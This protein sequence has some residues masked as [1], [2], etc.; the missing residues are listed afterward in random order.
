MTTRIDEAIKK[1]D[2]IFFKLVDLEEIFDAMTDDKTANAYVKERKDYVETCIQY[3]KNVSKM[4]E[5]VRLDAA[6]RRKRAE[7]RYQRALKF[8]PKQSGGDLNRRI[9]ELEE[10]VDDLK[11]RLEPK[12]LTILKEKLYDANRW[13]FG[14]FRSPSI[15]GSLKL[16]LHHWNEVCLNDCTINDPFKK[17]IYSSAFKKHYNVTSDDE[18]VKITKDFVIFVQI[19]EHGCYRRLSIPQ[20]KKYFGK[21]SVI[22]EGLC[23]LNT[24]KEFKH[25]LATSALKTLNLL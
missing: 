20:F 15:D 10:V 7:E 6:E 16:S 12:P 22:V 14:C 18:K 9:T 5:S 1:I 17:Q 13:I 11:R 25:T 8:F 19:I 4:P 23:D 21:G 2:E 3:E 24:E